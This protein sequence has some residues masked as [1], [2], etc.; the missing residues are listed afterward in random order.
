[1]NARVTEYR[2]SYFHSYYSEC[3]GAFNGYQLLVVQHTV[4]SIKVLICN[5]HITGYLV[6][7]KTCVFADT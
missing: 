4:G 2:Y 6:S 7:T 5:K 1:M 3:N